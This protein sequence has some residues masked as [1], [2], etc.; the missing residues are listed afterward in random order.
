MKN[1]R[2]IMKNS[3]V[4]AKLNVLEKQLIAQGELIRKLQEK[5]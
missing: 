3:R 5:I 1:F 2:V 4:I